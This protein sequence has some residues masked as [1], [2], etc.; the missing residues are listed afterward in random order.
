MSDT[1]HDESGIRLT[2]YERPAHDGKPAVYET[3]AYAGAVGSF[4]QPRA[5]M[6]ANRIER[7]DDT[8]DIRWWSVHFYSGDGAEARR[9]VLDTGEVFYTARNPADQNSQLF[10]DEATALAIHHAVAAALADDDDDNY[11]TT[12]PENH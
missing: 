10:I 3:T 1:T 2:K 9:H 5:T 6:R 12:T 11:T 7:P 8:P 4:T